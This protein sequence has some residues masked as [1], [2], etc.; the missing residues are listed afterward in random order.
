MTESKEPPS[1]LILVAEDD[2]AMR[3][4]LAD[5]LRD[6]GWEVVSVADGMEAVREL[7]AAPIRAVLTDLKMPNMDGMELLRHV[8][9][10]HPH[11]PVVMLTAHGSIPGAVDAMKVGA[12]DFI[13]K[14][15]GGPE[16]LRQVMSRALLA[17][18]AAVPLPDGWVEPIGSAPAFVE[19]LETAR[20]VAPRDTTVLLLS[21]SG[22]GKEVVARYIHRHSGRGDGPF[23][24][25]NC[26][27]IPETLLESQLFG[28]EKGA[29]TGAAAVRRGTFE[30]A[31]TGTLLLDEVGELGPALQAK[32]LRVLEEHAVTRLGG[33]KRIEVDVRVLSATN[34][35]L[36]EDVKKRRFREDLFFRLNV[37]PIRIPPLRERPGDILPMMRHF[38]AVKSGPAGRTPPEL[39]PAAESA[40]AGFPWPGN[41]RQ[42]MNV[43]ERALILAGPGPVEPGH[44]GL[45]EGEAPTE[46]TGTGEP[47]K[48]RPGESGRGRPAAT[49]REMEKQAI[50][51]ALSAVGGN[52]KKAAE[53][54]GIALR[55]LQYKLKQYGIT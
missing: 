21:E 33:N 32:F 22:T 19:A 23:V 26:A 8:V 5:I 55:T 53:R 2:R 47:G 10:D 51:D 14:P 34:R 28:H 46:S 6:A 49:L 48:A 41:V 4:L 3:E 45:D 12:F 36:Q 52:R 1:A 29:F 43:A 54:L 9:R 30:Q 13:T 15:L 50:I 16:E 39:S 24:A 17:S 7:K 38:M 44:L 37:F 18:G 42:L 31:H 25:L 11:V 35:D 27:A 20:T 40:L